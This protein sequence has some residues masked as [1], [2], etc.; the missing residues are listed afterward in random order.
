MGYLW[1]IMNYQ[2]VENLSLL[3]IDLMPVSGSYR[4]P[5]LCIK[6]FLTIYHDG[7]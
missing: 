4:F 2:P 6:H 3:G 1:L 5:S 7:S